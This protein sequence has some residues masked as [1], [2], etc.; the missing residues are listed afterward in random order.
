MALDGHTHYEMLYD[1]K[2]DLRTGMAF[3]VRGCVIVEPSEKLK[4]R[5]WTV[6]RAFNACDICALRVHRGLGP[7]VGTR[8]G[9]VDLLSARSSKYQHIPS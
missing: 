5:A 9:Q 2:K 8:S 7:V 3:G 6:S 4:K 1:V